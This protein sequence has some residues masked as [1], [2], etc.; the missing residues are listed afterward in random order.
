L[1]TKGI[2]RDELGEVTFH[3][4]GKKGDLICGDILALGMMTSMC[5]IGSLN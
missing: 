3:F 2:K 4:G 1:N 5:V